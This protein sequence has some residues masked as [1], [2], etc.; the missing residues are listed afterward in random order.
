VTDFAG[1]A[2]MAWPDALTVQVL[3]MSR[4][5]FRAFAET[6]K[7]TGRITVYN[8]KSLAEYSV[9]GIFVIINFGIRR[10]VQYYA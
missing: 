9:C 8:L 4:H 5:R 3:L 2:G 1:F 7:K 10:V 6:S